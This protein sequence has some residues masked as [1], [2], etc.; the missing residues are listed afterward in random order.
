MAIG[1]ELG[2]DVMTGDGDDDGVE[3]EDM[4]IGKGMHGGLALGWDG[5][6]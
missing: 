1:W 6:R 2:C 5:I 4:L 3:D